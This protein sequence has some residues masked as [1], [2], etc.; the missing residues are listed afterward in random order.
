MG[1]REFFQEVRAASLDAEACRN[2]LAKLEERALS[3]SRPHLEARVTGGSS[4]DRMASSVAA[5][6]DREGELHQRITRAY[7]LLDQAHLVLFGNDLDHGLASLCPGWWADVLWWRY[8][9]A[10]TWEET[11]QA[12]GYSERRCHQVANAALDICD[13]HGLAKTIGGDGGAEA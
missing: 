8:C 10:S 1:A 6:V 9:C 7:A 11:A 12:V 2:Q 5:M 4:P 13:A 3:I